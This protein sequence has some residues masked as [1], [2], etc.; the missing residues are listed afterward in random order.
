MSWWSG[1]DEAAVLTAFLFLPGLLVGAVLG[2]RRVVLLAAAPGLSVAILGLVPVLLAPTGVAWNPASAVVSAL[3]VA[4]L[5]AALRRAFRRGWRVGAEPGPAVWPVLVAVVLAAPFAALPMK[6][7]MAMPDLPPQTWDAVFHLNGIR[8]IVET[9]DG[10][11]LHLG[12]L[13]DPGTA[14]VFYPAAWHDIAALAL[15]DDVVVTANV[16]TLLLAA[17]I[18]PLALAGLAAVLAPRSWAAPAAAALAG[19]ALVA[20]PA[21][22][23]S[24]GTLWPSALAYALV[25]VALMLTLVLRDRLRR[26]HSHPRTAFPVSEVVALLAVLGGAGLAHPS[27]VLA[28]GVIGGAIWVH[29]WWRLLAAARRLG[30]RWRWAG[31]VA[32]PAAVLLGLAVFVASPQFTTTA[33]KKPEPFGSVTNAILGAFTDAQLPEVGF[34]NTERSWLIA[35][36]VTLGMVATVVVRRHRWLALA[37]VLTTALFVLSVDSSLPGA[38]LVG[39]WYSDPVRLGGMVALVVPVL[40]AVAVA[41]LAE[42]GARW[43]RPARRQALAQAVAA[44][45]VVVL[46]VGTGGLRPGERTEQMQ[47]NYL[48]VPESGLNGLVSPDELAMIERADETLPADA[49]VLGSPFTGAPLLYALSDVEVVYPHFRG[50]WSAEATH[51]ARHFNRLRFD[52][53][54]CADLNDLGIEYVYGD[55][56]IYWPEHSENENYRGL[57]GLGRL[58]DA[59]EPVDTGGT[60]TL[61]RITACG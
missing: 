57:V 45:L 6:N 49:V 39:P 20:F 8:A 19:T 58:G 5:F 27:A 14:T 53:G 24:Y 60:A 22:M 35:L 9:G 32:A 59:L 29:L 52:P 25:P 50:K 55:D 61:Y 48:F 36:L 23:V 1:L 37:M 11:S 30:G 13:A 4:V 44:A 54:V 7:G 26:W 51:L 16:F 47:T 31:V 42:A 40:V 21:R 10:S 56:L 3:V 38:F 41:W 12:R 28:Y 15:R 2:L 46:V 34:G 17:V 18:W 33:A 43:A